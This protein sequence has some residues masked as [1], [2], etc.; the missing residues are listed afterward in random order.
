MKNVI[1]LLLGFTILVGAAA[2]GTLYVAETGD[3]GNDGSTWPLAK[4]SIQGAV[5][6][7]GDGD[8]ILVSNGTY[9]AAVDP[10]VSISKSVDIRGVN[11]P[12]VT[13]IDGENARRCV[14]VYSSTAGGPVYMSGFAIRNGSAADGA[15]VYKGA[16]RDFYLSNCVIHAN[17]S[18]ANGSGIYK[19]SILSQMVVSD[20]IVSNNLAGGY[21]GGAYSSYARLFMYDCEIVNNTS[22]NGGGGIYGTSSADPGTIFELHGCRIVNNSSVSNAGGGI[23]FSGRAGGTGV[24]NNCVVAF[25]H[26]S[27]A[28]GGI[29][30][31]GW[32]GD[33][34]ITNCI[35]R[36]NDADY[37][38]GYAG[39][40]LR[41][42]G[43]GRMTGC[44]IAG[45]KATAVGGYGGGLALETGANVF[46]VNNCTIVSNST[47]DNRGG[48]LAAPATVAACTIRNTIIF[49]NTSDGADRS[50]VFVVAGSGIV[51]TN[52]CTAPLDNGVD[53]PITPNA[54]NMDYDPSLISLES[55]N[56]RLQR[57]SPCINAGANMPWMAGAVDL[58]GRRRLDRFSGLVDLGCYEYVL[59][60]TIFSL[61]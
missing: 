48:G 43:P 44:L 50:N 23:N 49:H 20:C 31:R 21:G 27:N 41:I 25:N 35:I 22:T 16:Y 39:A 45:N 9:T 14:Y 12:G 7:A 55:G 46:E 36:G 40:G 38:S 11:G 59:E 34:F 10:V 15:G 37:A 5:N 61:K 26:A 52:C 56:Y 19:A 8:V 2:A 28:G 32:P 18:F 60:G 57:N 58:D 13:I 3:D 51:F 53:Q 1:C 4:R 29:Y 33:L 47:M 42:S 30:H 6:A 54:D 17:N 24:V